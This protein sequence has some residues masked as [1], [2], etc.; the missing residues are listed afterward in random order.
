MPAADLPPYSDN[1]ATVSALPKP[2]VLANGLP[3]A[4]ELRP[5]KRRAL[6]N[7]QQHA[8]TER[9]PSEVGYSGAR[10]PM[11][12]STHQVGTSERDARLVTRGDPQALQT[13]LRGLLPHEEEL[14]Q[15]SDTARLQGTYRRVASVD[16]TPPTDDPST[17]GDW[18]TLGSSDGH[19]YTPAPH[20]GVGGSMPSEVQSDPATFV[21]EGQ[22]KSAALYFADATE[23]EVLKTAMRLAGFSEKTMFG[24]VNALLGF[25][26]WLFKV[27]RSA[28]AARLDTPFLEQDLKDYASTGRSSTHVAGALNTMKTLKNYGTL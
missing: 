28:F 5:T 11:Q 7:R 1:T 3:D 18:L 27:G 16:V 24:K 23:I 6:N 17:W 25:G 22:D 9:Q 14:L 21:H 4:G 15:L 10:V 12:S 20:H 8:A 19:G 26:R 13:R 2:Q